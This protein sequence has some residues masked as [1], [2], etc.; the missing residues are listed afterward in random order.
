MGN[1]FVLHVTD[2]QMAPTILAG[3]TAIV[4][5]SVKPLPN[6]KDV[7][8][9]AVDGKIHVCRFTRRENRIVMAY[10]NGTTRIIPESHVEIIGKVILV[11]FNPE[12][13]PLENEENRSVGDTTAFQ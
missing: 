1:L 3:D 7:A 8:V 10:D 12:I 11:S 5:T 9:L 2:D 4:D 6:G 13:K